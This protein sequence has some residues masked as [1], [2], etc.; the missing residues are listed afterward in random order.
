[1]SKEILDSH[2]HIGTE[3]AA[4]YEERGEAEMIRLGRSSKNIKKYLVEH[5]ISHA[6]VF[7]LPML[8]HRQKEA[9]EEILQLVSGDASLI[10][11]AFLDPRLEES[12]GLLK[13]LVNRGCRGLKLHP[14]CHGY[15]VS[16]SMCYP[17]LEEAQ[18]LGIPVLIHSGWGEYGEIRFIKRMA[19]DFPELSVVIA[20]LIEHKDVFTL[21]PDLE[22]VFVET[23][24]STHP[25]RISQAVNALGEE[26]VIF[27]SD[28]PLTHPGF[29]LM[30]VEMA[31]ITDGAREK[32]LFENGARLI[33]LKK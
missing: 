6:V 12:P 32:I 13:E 21:V 14:I 19:E 33:G 1:M 27:G 8:P 7:A 5:D 4:T 11:F 30:K 10:P 16:N 15:V 2:T 28:M 22:N 26:R 25:R 24:Y 31:P 9:N 18:L 20:H 23:S 3:R 29:E 17:T